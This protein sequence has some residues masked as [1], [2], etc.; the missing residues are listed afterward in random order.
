MITGNLHLPQFGRKYV[1]ENEMNRVPIVHCSPFAFLLIPV[2]PHAIMAAAY[3]YRLCW[4]E[5]S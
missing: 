2:H 5:Y 3:T 4:G 1:M